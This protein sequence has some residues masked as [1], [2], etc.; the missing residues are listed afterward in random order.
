MGYITIDS[1]TSSTTVLVF[2]DNLNVLKK[3]QKKHKQI[4]LCTAH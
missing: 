1:S 4:N 2:D 3:I